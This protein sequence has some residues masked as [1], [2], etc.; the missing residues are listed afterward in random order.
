[1][2]AVFQLEGTPWIVV[3]ARDGEIDVGVG[4]SEVDDLRRG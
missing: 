1:M 4:V 2:K 3:D